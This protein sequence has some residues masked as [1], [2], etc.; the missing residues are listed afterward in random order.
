MPAHNNDGL[1]A[2]AEYAVVIRLLEDHTRPVPRHELYAARADIGGERLDAAIVSLAEAQ[3]VT[4]EGDS[5]RSAPALERLDDL[6][7]IA[8]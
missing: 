1:D 2:A 8:I 5:V 6:R 4:T 3:V 7:L